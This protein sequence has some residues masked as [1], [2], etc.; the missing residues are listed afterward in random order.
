[1]LRV[2]NFLYSFEKIST[3]KITILIV[4]AALLES[5]M[6]LLLLPLINISFDDNQTQN[7]NEI[8]SYYLNSYGYS[9]AELFVLII[10]LFIVINVIILIN[11]YKILSFSFNLGHKYSIRVID[12]FIN[13]YLYSFKNENLSVSNT[14]NKVTSDSERLSIYVGLSYCNFIHKTSIFTFLYI[15]LLVYNIKITFIL[16]SIFISFYL[17]LILILYKKNNL[18]KKI[19]QNSS[20]SRFNSTKNLLNGI[21]TLDIYQKIDYFKNI[22]IVNSLSY[23]TSRFKSEFFT[24]FPRTLLELISIS[25]ILILLLFFY[26]N[27]FQLNNFFLLFSSYAIVGYKLIPSMQNIYANFARMQTHSNVIDT[28]KN[29]INI[30]NLNNK[31]SSLVTEKFLSMEISKL[32]FSY[33]NKK[34]FDD[35]NFKIKSG[36]IFCVAGNSGIG[37]S[38]LIKILLGNEKTSKIKVEINGEIK[39]ISDFKQYVSF[40]AQEPFLIN[41]TLA[42]NISLD[43]SNNSNQIIKF[44]NNIDVNFD[45]SFTNYKKILDDGSNLSAGQKQRIEFLRSLFFDKQIIIL[46]E[47]TSNLDKKTELK[48]IEILQK[49]GK[50]I[51]LSTHSN[52]ILKIS[53]KI[54]FLKDTNNYVLSNYDKLKDDE[55][56]TKIFL[57]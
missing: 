57:E 25:I 51:I 16:T 20:I 42:D 10:I 54:L 38:T 36:E 47:P 46:D 8:L 4:F 27:N 48:I 39:Q 50:T 11:T 29:I 2:F 30:K 55:V 6:I 18:Y 53:N 37:K 23:N 5:L 19:M 56:F 52:E 33:E 34:I 21:V 14:L 41:G 40:A 31:N 45:N 15:A 24:F 1:M 43:F 3:I 7:Y 35:L 12:N 17:I 28:F 13:N 9:F 26:I 22:F 49:S 32:E 44:L